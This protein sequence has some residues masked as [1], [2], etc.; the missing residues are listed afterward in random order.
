MWYIHTHER[1]AYFVK[2]LYNLS[3]CDSGLWM[4]SIY[5]SQQLKVTKAMSEENWPLVTDE[6]IQFEK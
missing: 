3:G 5:V 2:I 4:M 6:L 1:Q